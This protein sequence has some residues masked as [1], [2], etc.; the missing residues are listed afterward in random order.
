[1]LKTK[2]DQHDFSSRE[3][4]LLREDESDSDSFLSAES[5]VEVGFT[6]STVGIG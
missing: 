6:P 3:L 5:D 2:H 1:M 4:P